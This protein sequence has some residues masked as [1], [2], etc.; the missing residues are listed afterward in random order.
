MLVVMSPEAEASIWVEREIL[1]AQQND[2]TTLP[3]LLRGKGMSLLITQQHVDVR[4]GEMPPATFYA[5][6]RRTVARAAAAE[7][8]PSTPNQVA[9]ST[10][11]L[12]AEPDRAPMLSTDQR[13]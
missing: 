1:L 2:K 9:P 4:H 13:R 11:M 12:P 6:L 5:Q 7:S 3:L 8:Q 10:P